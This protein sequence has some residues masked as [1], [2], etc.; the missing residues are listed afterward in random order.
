MIE[1]IV[2]FVVAN[3][4]PVIAFYV[5]GG[6]LYAVL[7]WTLLLVKLRRR[8]LEINARTDQDDRDKSMSRNEAARK[9]FGEYSY[10][11]KVSENKGNLLTWATFWP[12]NLVWTMFADVAREAWDFLYR[13]FGS[14]LQAIATSILPK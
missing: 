6:A 7:K 2:A 3:Y 4:I 11:P 10:P 8:V 12:I 14:M 13:K 9:I 1:A 5:A